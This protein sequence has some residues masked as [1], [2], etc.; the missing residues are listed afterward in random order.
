MGNNIPNLR[1]AEKAVLR[2]KFKAIN[3]T[4]RKKERSQISNL[5]V[6]LKE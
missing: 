3:V 5:I 4:A 2:A 6:Q 1:D